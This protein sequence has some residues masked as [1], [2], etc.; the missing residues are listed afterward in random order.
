MKKG[1]F[2]TGTDTDIGKTFTT[3]GLAGSL[4]ELGIDVGVFKPMMSGVKREDPTSDAY[5]LKQLSKDEHSLEVINPFQF[6]EPLAPYLASKRAGKLISIE[7]ILQKWEDIKNTH[8]CYLVEGAG[9]LA[10]PLGGSF[11]VSDLARAIGFPLI[12]IARP[13]LGTVNHTL[14]TIHY[15]KSM[16]LK[17]AGVIINGLKEE[18]T[19]VAEQTN[20]SLI[21]EFSGIPVIGVIPW[22]KQPTSEKIIQSIKQNVDIQKLVIES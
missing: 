21:E 8:D 16:G 5:L 11:L 10:V 18:Q 13:S 14:L 4:R 22:V 2:I 1:F 6:D 12:I 7:E 17:V 15:A 19:G 20:P 3:A 9:G